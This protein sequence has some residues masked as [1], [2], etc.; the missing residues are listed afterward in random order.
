MDVKPAVSAD[1]PAIA[2]L[3]HHGWMQGH[4]AA[5]PKSLI[6]QRTADE[7]L[8]RTKAHLAQTQV[9]CIKGEMAG[10]FM[11]EG[12]ELYQFYVAPG[13]QGSGVA[14]ELMA[15]AEAALGDGLKWL[16]CL[17][18]NDRA[19]RFYEKSGWVLAA[20]V[21]YEVETEEGPYVINSWRF[22]K[23]LGAAR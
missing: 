8:T 11:I 9:A 14:T 22:E 5:A 18:G 7:F 16:A 13:F 3:W 20:T 10:F 12:D 17:V 15:K 19:A 4:G 1:I 2:A 6:N 23:R 21:P